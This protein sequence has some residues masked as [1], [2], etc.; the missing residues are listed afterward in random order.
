[1]ARR[2]ITAETRT[3]VLE[4]ANLQGPK[5]YEAI[6]KQYGVSVPT[7]YN[8]LRELKPVTT[9]TPTEVAAQ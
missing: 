1:M 8:W 5:H 2:T 6:A 3:A 4:A 9:E 7:I